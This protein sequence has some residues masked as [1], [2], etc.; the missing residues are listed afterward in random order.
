MAKIKVVK[1]M[2]RSPGEA[3]M[4]RFVPLREYQLWKY[5]MIH[6]H[7]KIVDG[8]E[9]SI[10]VDAQS[11]AE[12]PPVQALPLE[13]VMRVDLQYWDRTMKTTMVAQRFFPADEYPAI[14]DI[15]L[16][17][18]PDEAPEDGRGSS[19]KRVKETRGYYLHPRLPSLPE[20]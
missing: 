5:F 4:V 6:A 20:V 2:L 19:G 3:P 14:K 1:C 9:V 17:H 16:G 11:Y 18:Y 8:E 10:W 15:Y 13:G 12:Q 7:N